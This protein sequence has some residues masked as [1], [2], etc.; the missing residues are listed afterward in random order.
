[1]VGAVDRYWREQNP[2]FLPVPDPGLGKRVIQ[3]SDHFRWLALIMVGSGNV[4][5]AGDLWDEPVRA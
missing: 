3:L 4:D 5:I 2:K 1:M